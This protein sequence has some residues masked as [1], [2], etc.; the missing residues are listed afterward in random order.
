MSEI[1]AA[2]DNEPAFIP[3]LA[4]GDPTY[5]ASLQYVHSVVDHGADIV[6]LGLPFS[7]PIAD[8]STIRA[9]TVRSLEAG[10][11]PE[12]FFEFVTDLDVEVPLVCMT[13]YNLIYQYG[14]EPGPAPFV[15]AAGDVGIN[16]IIVPDLPAEEAEPLR[17]A[18][19]QFGL[20][21]IF[22][23]APTTDGD[24]L[25]AIRG[26]GSGY[27]YVQAQLGTTGTRQGVSGQTKQSL[28]RIQDWDLPKAVGFGIQSGEQ[29]EQIVGA[30]ADG[31]IVG[32]ALVDRIADGYE[33]DLSTTTTASRLGELARE[34]KAGAVRGYQR[35]QVEPEGT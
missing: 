8:G 24:R 27:V 33:Q 21:L 3:Y 10:M 20:D 35:R 13:Y 31:I 4:A 1:R 11:T 29:A 34:L 18:C 22:I 6:E 19:N 26:L 30:G 9:A 12:R 5:E 17:A 15:R 25:E 2:F 28:D 23:V 14:Q 7:D 16:G 32:S